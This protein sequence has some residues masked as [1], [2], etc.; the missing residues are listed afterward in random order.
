MVVMPWP[1]AEGAVSGRCCWLLRT[2]KV[3]VWRH[4]GARIDRVAHVGATE[5]WHRPAHGRFGI[6][7]G[8]PDHAQRRDPGDAS[9]RVSRRQPEGDRDIVHFSD[10]VA[11][12]VRDLEG[13]TEPALVAVDV[14][15]PVCKIVRDQSRHQP[16]RETRRRYVLP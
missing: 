8:L 2:P 14:G 3:S 6:E 13:A 16:E 9:I 11:A 7:V 12:H 5:G 4:D 10:R 1:G 15:G